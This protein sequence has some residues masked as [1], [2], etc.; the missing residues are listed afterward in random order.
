MGDPMADDTDLGPMAREDLRDGIHDQVMESVK[1][2]A[3]IVTGGEIPSQTGYYYPPTLLD[4]LAIDHNTF[5]I[6]KFAHTKAAVLSA[7][8]TFFNTTKR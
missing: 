3:N 4:K 8:T 2:G 6:H 5:D 1:A 7:V